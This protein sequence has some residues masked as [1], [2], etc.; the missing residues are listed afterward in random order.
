M[1]TSWMNE[2]IRELLS[3]VRVQSL[4]VTPLCF[5][6]AQRDPSCAFE[7]SP[8]PVLNLWTILFTVTSP[9][10]AIWYFGSWKLI[11]LMLAP[12]LCLIYSMFSAGDTHN[13]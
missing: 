10:L 8:L 13:S 9:Q 2:W 3:I 1:G 5:L 7:D 11:S 12:W 4:S 6:K